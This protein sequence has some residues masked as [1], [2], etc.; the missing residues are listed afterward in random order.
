MGRAGVA[1]IVS[2]NTIPGETAKVDVSGDGGQT[3]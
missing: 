2:A 1:Q 3:S